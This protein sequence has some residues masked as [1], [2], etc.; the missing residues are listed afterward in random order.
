MKTIL[1]LNFIDNFVLCRSPLFL[2]FVISPVTSRPPTPKS[3]SEY[4]KARKYDATVQT[5]L[6]GDDLVTMDSVRWR[7]G[8]L[9]ETCEPESKEQL[10]IT[11]TSTG[12][13]VLGRDGGNVVFLVYYTHC[14]ML[15]VVINIIVI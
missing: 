3:D 10:A 4:E 1:P 6:T 15:L 11:A 7:W 13:W 8:E 2:Y 12:V 14:C 5:Y 9:P